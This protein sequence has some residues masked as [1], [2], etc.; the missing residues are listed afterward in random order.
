MAPMA[1]CLVATAAVAWFAFL[2][3][4][5]MAPAAISATA[6]ALGSLVCHQIPARSFHVGA[7]QLPVCARCIGIYGGAAV[8]AVVFAIRTPTG[9]IERGRMALLIGAL[10]VAIT[11]ALE[12]S[13][14]WAAGNVLRAATGVAMG[15]AASF[16]VMGAVPTLHYDECAPRRPIAPSR[17][18]T[19]I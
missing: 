6:Y 19:S 16:V 7:S 8:G 2:L 13:G 10:P 14:V 15:L 17:P 3:V 11:V 4:A 12:S 9:A 1:T 5:P 18:R